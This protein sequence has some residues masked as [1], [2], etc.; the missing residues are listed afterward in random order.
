MLAIPY[1][2]SLLVIQRL[3]TNILWQNKK[4]TMS[5]LNCSL[6]V[7]SWHL[8]NFVYYFYFSFQEIQERELLRIQKVA[9]SLQEFARYICQNL[10][11]NKNSRFRFSITE[12]SRTLLQS[13]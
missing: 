3:T 7:C 13:T 2:V 12:P 10:P 4:S 8:I 9:K 1:C 5:L 11:D 6:S